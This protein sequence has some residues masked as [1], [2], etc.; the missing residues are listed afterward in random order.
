MGVLFWHATPDTD[1]ACSPCGHS[2]T[3]KIPSFPNRGVTKVVYLRE[4]SGGFWGLG[5][6]I[7]GFFSKSR[8]PQGTPSKKPSWVIQEHALR[9]TGGLHDKQTDSSVF[10]RGVTGI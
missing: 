10:A 1:D 5:Q 3:E 2:S 9:G 7:Q 6:R 4:P 8:F